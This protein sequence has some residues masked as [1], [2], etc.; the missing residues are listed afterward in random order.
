MDDLLEITK[1]KNEGP[2]RKAF[3]G[4]ITLIGE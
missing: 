4:H 1:E 2:Y 3:L